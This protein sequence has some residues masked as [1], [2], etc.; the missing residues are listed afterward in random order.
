MMGYSKYFEIV[1][2]FV[3]CIEYLQ[4]Y[5]ELIGVNYLYYY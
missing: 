5:H 1:N 3:N 4:T 2:G